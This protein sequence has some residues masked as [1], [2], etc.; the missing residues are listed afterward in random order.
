MRQKDVGGISYIVQTL[1]EAILS[2]V[3]SPDSDLFPSAKNQLVCGGMEELSYG[4]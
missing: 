1:M 3:P 2:F 4:V